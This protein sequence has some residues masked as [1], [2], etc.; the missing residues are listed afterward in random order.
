M[1]WVIG[2]LLVGLLVYLLLDTPPA[3]LLPRKR[4]CDYSVAGSR[5]VASISQGIRLLEVHLYSDEQDQPVVTPPTADE[6]LSFEQVCVSI[7]NDAFPSKDPFIL[8]IVPHTEKT[9]VLDRAAEHLKTTV[10]KHLVSAKDIEQA[11]LDTLANKLILVS[12]NVAGSQLEPLLNLSWLN[13]NLRRLNVT[14]AMYPRDP[15]ELQRYNRDHISMVASDL[16]VT[17]SIPFVYGCQWV[18]Q[19]DRTPGFVEKTFL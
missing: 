19:A 12:G 1:E 16:P 2:L 8:S 11:P 14:Q 15:H 3:R 7:V 10:R 9:I 13:S 18:V 4:L 5:D 6:A 17:Y